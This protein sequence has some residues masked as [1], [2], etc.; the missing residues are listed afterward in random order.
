MVESAVGDSAGSEC[1]L[2]LCDG[3]RAGGLSSS[4]RS[5]ASAGLFRRSQQANGQGNPH[6]DCRRNGFVDGPVQFVFK[7]RTRL[8]L[9]TNA[10]WIALGHFRHIELQGMKFWPRCTGTIAA[11]DRVLV[12]SLGEIKFHREVVKIQMDQTIVLS[13][14]CADLLESSCSAL[15]D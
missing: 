10:K 4:L 3:G 12:W 2:C 13:C 15:G 7:R 14:D 1:G 8:T 5:Q 9:I 11:L 6:T